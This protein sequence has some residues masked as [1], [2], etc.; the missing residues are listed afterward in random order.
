M[1]IVLVGNIGTGKSTY[2]RNNYVNDEKIISPDGW[3]N[4]TSNEKDIK[5]LQELHNGLENND[6]VV[7]DGNNISK[8]ARK[9]Y[10]DLA[11]HYNQKS[12]AIDFGSG[13]N[14]TLDRRITA[15]PNENALV[16]RKSHEGYQ[17]GYEQPELTEGFDKVI[18]E[19]NY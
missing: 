5:F 18:R 1:I 15:S 17:R 8:I 2:I 4:L 9:K 13:S 16:W 12:L 11:Q 6:T 14:I 19:I 3:D 7:V 10:I